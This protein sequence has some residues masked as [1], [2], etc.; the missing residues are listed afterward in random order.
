MEVILLEQVRK[1]GNLGDIVS[2]KN[3]FARNYLL[4]TNKALMATA[5][6]KEV[7]ERKKEEI[8]KSNK[9]AHSAATKLFDK[10]DKLFVTLIRQ[11][12]EDGRLFGSVYSRDISDEISSALSHQLN[13]SN[14]VDLE[15]IKYLGVYEVD[16]VLH[17]E[18]I[19]T[20]RVIVARSETEAL[21][22][23]KNFLNPPKP[24]DEEKALFEEL[25]AQQKNM[26][27]DDAGEEDESLSED[28]SD[29]SG[30]GEEESN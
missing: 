3:G 25:A 6:N 7:F 20:A 30:A 13:K 16:L 2:V 23:K 29:F 1:L 4:P 12:G 22:A 24:K 26:Q 5:E 9:E 27:D 17:P 21:E 28:A 14:V 18:V 15:P 19:A 10:A 11:A 8:A